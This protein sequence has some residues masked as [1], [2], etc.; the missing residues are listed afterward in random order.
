MFSASLTLPGCY[1]FV[2]A[3]HLDLLLLTS[4][5]AG[6]VFVDSLMGGPSS[7]FAGG[8]TYPDAQG[9]PRFSQT[10]LNDKLL[11]ARQ[12]RAEF[13]QSVDLLVSQLEHST[14]DLSD[15]ATWLISLTTDETSTRVSWANADFLAQ[16]TTTH[17]PPRA[18]LIKGDCVNGTPEGPFEAVSFLESTSENIAIGKTT[19]A[20][21]SH[22]QATMTN[23]EFD[24]EVVISRQS[25]FT[26]EFMPTQPMYSALVGTYDS[27]KPIGTHLTWL[28]MDT[29]NST[30][31]TRYL[32][33][34]FVESESYVGSHRA[35]R[36]YNYMDT[37]YGWSSF[38]NPKG[39]ETRSC[40]WGGT[41]VTEERCASFLTHPPLQNKFIGTGLTV[42]KTPDNIYRIGK[43]WPNT[44]AAKAGLLAGDQLVAIDQRVISPNDELDS[45]HQ[46]IRGELDSVVELSVLRAGNLSTQ[47]FLV[48]RAEIIFP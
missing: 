48:K 13:V 7:M 14:C 42:S 9:Y 43:V 31:L 45:I 4:G 11:K 8:G 33:N 3:P 10:E 29:Q 24:G 22:V 17:T 36:F 5:A 12:A 35:S 21:F 46:Q 41:V 34:N 30:T 19:F 25:K 6:G 39:E 18:A 20:W 40:F 37:M 23:G 38:W 26:G 28:E 47:P 32:P 27:G 16:T 44:P 2:G 1:T 15:E